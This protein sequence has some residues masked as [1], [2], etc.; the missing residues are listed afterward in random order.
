MGFPYA[1]SSLSDHVANFR[2]HRWWAERGLIHWEHRDTGNYG[3]L[4]VR[5]CLIRLRAL[6]DMVENSVKDSHETGQKLMYQN[7]IED[8]QRFIDEMIDLCQRA[9]E[10]GTPFDK[11][12][13]R[14]LKRRRRTVVPAPSGRA[15]F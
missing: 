13:A 7:E 5:M 8:H 9:R 1:L 11:S 12:A 4:S 14:D 10:Q 3:T 6:N 2:K 15:A